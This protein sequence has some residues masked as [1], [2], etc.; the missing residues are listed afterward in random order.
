MSLDLQPNE[1]KRIKFYSTSGKK[2]PASLSSSF[3]LS[4]WP[5]ITLS[6]ILPVNVFIPPPSRP[7]KE[8]NI[9]NGNQ[10]VINLDN[11]K[12]FKRE[13]TNAGLLCCNKKNELNSDS[14][15]RSSPIFNLM[16][17]IGMIVIVLVLVVTL[18]GE[19]LFYYFDCF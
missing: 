7:I 15:W 13:K 3:P 4:N 5:K 18:I 2:V 10:H 17:L 12:H 14:I 9:K 1:R 19:F 11:Q 6:P 16:I 8:L